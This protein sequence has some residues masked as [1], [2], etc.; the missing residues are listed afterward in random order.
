MC[1]TTE[2]IL[3]KIGANDEA[4]LDGAVRSAQTKKYD[5]DETGKTK[6]Q[7]FE[8]NAYETAACWSTLLPES[9]LMFRVTN[10]SLRNA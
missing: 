4:T 5:V 2:E 6:V 9:F 8:K 1:K 10:S 7:V 3:V